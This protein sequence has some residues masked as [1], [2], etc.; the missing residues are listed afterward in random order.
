MTAA[1]PLQIHATVEDP[2]LPPSSGRYDSDTEDVLHPPTSTEV[3]GDD[4]QHGAAQESLHL[5]LSPS[6]QQH[7]MQ[8]VD[9]SGDGRW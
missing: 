3:Q 5:V 8:G 6:Q 9:I 1:L 2:S 4:S 7:E